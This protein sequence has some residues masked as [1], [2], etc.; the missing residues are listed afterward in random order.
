MLRPTSIDCHDHSVGGPSACQ[1]FVQQYGQNDCE[2]KLVTIAIDGFTFELISALSLN[3]SLTNG[4]FADA[5]FFDAAFPRSLAL[6]FKTNQLY[7]F[8]DNSPVASSAYGQLSYLVTFGF[9][10]CDSIITWTDYAA[11]FTIQVVESNLGDRPDTIYH[12]FEN[13]EENL[14]FP[15]KITEEYNETQTS[16]NYPSIPT[17]LIN[18]YNYPEPWFE[19][20]VDNRHDTTIGGNNLGFADLLQYSYTI[21]DGELQIIGMAVTLKG[22]YVDACLDEAS[23]IVY[24]N[25]YGTDLIDGLSDE[26][27]E[28]SN[29][30]E[31]SKCAADVELD[32]CL[33]AIIAREMRN[34]QIINS[35]VSSGLTLS[36]PAV[37]DSRL[38]GIALIIRNK[39][40]KFGS[41]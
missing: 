37:D 18:S 33:L 15:I 40:Q 7:T 31:C 34:T 21:G 6:A 10:T 27:N 16:T 11:S 13:T 1:L 29:N 19:C 28:Y 5:I 38:A 20:E 22:K 24:E 26:V 23:T 25:S 9:S 3:I 30:N 2:G 12:Q 41:I 8:I 4:L 32:D 14:A 17:T 36:M 35:D 39:R